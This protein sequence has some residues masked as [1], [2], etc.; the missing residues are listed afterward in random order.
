LDAEPVRE[1]SCFTEDLRQLA[2]WLV[3]KG[4]Q[5]VAMQS[6]GVYWIPLYDILEEHGLEVFLVNAKYTKNLPG[7]KT[8]VQECQWLLK[9]HTYGLLTNSFR[10]PGE[11]LSMRSYWRLRQQHI[12]EASTTVQRIQKVLTEMNLQL[13]N[14]IS[15][16]AGVS[17]MAIIRA[18]IDGERDRQKLA[19]L[20]DARIRASSHQVA[21]SL[22]GNWREDLLFVLKQQVANYDHFQKQIG[23]CDEQLQA[24]LQRFPSADRPNRSAVAA[25]P[26]AAKQRSKKSKKAK[27]NAPSFNVAQELTRITGVDLTLIDGVD[28]MTAQTI[29]SEIGCDMRRWKTEAHFASW[30]G[31]S[32]D[33][34]ISGGVV[35][36]RGTRKVINRTAV[37]LRM[38]AS[39]LIKC[40]SYLGAQYRRLRTRLGAPKA[41]T[42]MAHKLARIVYRMLKYRDGYVDKGADF[43]EQKYREQQI[44]SIK[45][46][47]EKLGLRVVPV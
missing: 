32:P 34:R 19:G 21:K 5:T 9:L 13:A 36:G 4:I 47:A 37:A 12:Q 45:K 11:V 42:A 22:E 46:R 16:I 18:I 2:R 10:P 26:S 14:V 24:H 35:L 27:G 6:T 41:I 3:D 33:N 39:T 31:L 17:G 40:E 20:C 15:D 1:F 25:Q 43:Y 29:F 7:R 30:L 23:L 38:A 44:H 28:A 8:D